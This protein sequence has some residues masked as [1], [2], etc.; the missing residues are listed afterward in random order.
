MPRRRLIVLPEPHTTWVAPSLAFLT[1]WK[2]PRAATVSVSILYC[3]KTQ[4]INNHNDQNFRWTY[5]AVILET[6][7]CSVLGFRS[8]GG[9]ASGLHEDSILILFTGVVV[10]V[11]VGFG[12]VKG[13]FGGEGVARQA[14]LD[15]SITSTE[16]LKLIF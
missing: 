6:A 4:I 9:V 5:S 14:E 15:P 13:G 11:G 7:I 1:T 2:R 3:L 10:M 8:R 16:G 12:G